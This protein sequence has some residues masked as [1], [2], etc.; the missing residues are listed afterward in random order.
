M[1]GMR[2]P[3]RTPTR[4][5]GP[6]FPLAPPARTSHSRPRMRVVRDLHGRSWHVAVS[7][8]TSGAAPPRAPFAHTSPV[9]A[10]CGSMAHALRKTARA[11][12]PKRLDPT[13]APPPLCGS[14]PT[15]RSHRRKSTMVVPQGAGAGRGS[16]ALSRRN[17]S[18][19]V[20]AGRATRRGGG[21]PPERVPPTDERQCAPRGSRSSSASRRRC[22]PRGAWSRSRQRCHRAPRSGRR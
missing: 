17:Q 3:L 6:H 5:P 12:G 9:G 2:S 8:G 19:G 18:P 7:Y 14:C 1:R 4:A 10:R 13:G 21:R 16:A 20:R 11:I 15:A 22:G